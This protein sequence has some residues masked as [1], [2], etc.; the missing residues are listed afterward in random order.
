MV[1]PAV[2]ARDVVKKNRASVTQ[3]IRVRLR[4]LIRPSPKA[5][6]TSVKWCLSLHGRNLGF[7]SRL[8]E[9]VFAFFIVTKSASA[10]IEV[11]AP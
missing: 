10:R 2:A 9:A 8:L 1:V 3:A 7:Y 4:R 5:F 11:A 6:P